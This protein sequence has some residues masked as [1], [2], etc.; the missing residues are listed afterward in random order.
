LRREVMKGG[1]VGEQRENN[2]EGREQ[3]ESR[4]QKEGR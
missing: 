2:R 3:K 1:N 4:E